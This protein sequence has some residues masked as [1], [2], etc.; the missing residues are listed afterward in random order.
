MGAIK[1]NLYQSLKSI[2]NNLDPNATADQKANQIA[3]AVENAI[4]QGLQVTIPAGKVIIQ[5]QSG[6]PNPSAIN[7]ELDS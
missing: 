2:F 6:V 7:C 1:S 4:L 3:T 5:A